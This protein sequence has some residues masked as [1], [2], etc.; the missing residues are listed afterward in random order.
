[1]SRPKKQAP[2]L[3]AAEAAVPEAAATAAVRETS[4]ARLPAKALDF[5]RKKLIEG[6][7]YEN[8]VLTVIDEFGIVLPL[9][10]VED[11]FRSNPGLQKKRVESLLA[12]KAWLK[13]KFRKGEDVHSG[14]ADTV[15]LVGLMGV[16]A[17]T[18]MQDFGNAMKYVGYKANV[19]FKTHDMDIKDRKVNLAADLAVSK[20]EHASAQTALLHA[21]LER[22][23]NRVTCA[24][25]SN[26]RGPETIERIHQIY[27]LASE[28]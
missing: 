24:K 12:A 28:N 13:E 19:E 7:T 8:V 9:H 10:A 5:V 18:Q 21:E 16:R 11:Y 15:L 1:M 22:L 2:R 23:K 6:S 27:G 20:K 4:I 26:A 25:D 14:L 3:I 17:S